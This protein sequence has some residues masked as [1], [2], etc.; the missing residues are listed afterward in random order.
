MGTDGGEGAPPA[1]L[2]EAL[3]LIGPKLK[4]S[5]GTLVCG[6][7]LILVTY[8][9]KSGIPLR[10]ED[11]GLLAGFLGL[12]REETARVLD[13]HD[14]ALRPDPEGADKMILCRG[15]SCSL[16]GADNLHPQLKAGLEKQ[17][18]KREYVEVFCLGQCER[19]PSI[20]VG[21]EIYCSRAQVVIIDERDWRS[22]QS[23]H[24][25]LEDDS[26]PVRD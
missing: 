6:A 22:E 20:M 8:L 4:T 19:G 21:R 26:V 2:A 24:I 13:F 16:H 11:L 12:E 17:G 10:D 23:D 14:K 7:S 9:R 5:E 25:S 18:M 1:S 3:G 15:T